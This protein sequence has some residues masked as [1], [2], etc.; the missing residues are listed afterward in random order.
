[1]SEPRDAEFFSQVRSLCNEGYTQNEV[2][3]KFGISRSYVSDIVC[4]RAGWCPD[5][6]A[7]EV[8]QGLKDDRAFARK[9]LRE[10]LRAEVLFKEAA[11]VACKHIKPLRAKAAPKF[12]KRE[13]AID[14]TA[15]LVLSDG[16]HDQV[17][18]WTRLSLTSPTP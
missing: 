2:A 9:R 11:E 6:D 10:A 14:E 15:V 16:H 18:S 5:E 4:G 3:K 13:G 7:M 17:V 1:M 12:K 8:I